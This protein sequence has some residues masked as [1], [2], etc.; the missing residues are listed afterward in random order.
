M[1]TK[2]I[3]ILVDLLKKQII[4]PK[5]KIHSIAGLATTAKLTSVENKITDVIN[6]VKKNRLWCRNIRH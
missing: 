4:M 1:Q 3:L 6:F 2:K 5:G